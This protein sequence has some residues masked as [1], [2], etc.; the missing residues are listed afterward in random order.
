MTFLSYFFP[1]ICPIS[2]SSV[3]NF[4]KENVWYSFLIS[5]QVLYLKFPNWNWNLKRTL[6]RIVCVGWWI[7]YG[8]PMVFVQIIISPF[9]LLSRSPT[10]II[11]PSLWLFGI[12]M[13]SVKDDQFRLDFLFFCWMKSNPLW[14]SLTDKSIY[15]NEIDRMLTN[16]QWL[17]FY[18]NKPITSIKPVLWINNV[19]FIKTW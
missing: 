16:R 12:T 7:S 11:L 10:M 2:I 4:D 8:V 6:A 18:Y 9:M 13:W 15:L 5:G 19:A 17:Q 3:G 14:L 1:Q